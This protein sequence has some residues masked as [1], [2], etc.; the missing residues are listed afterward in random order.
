MITADKS[1]LA[2]AV[3]YRFFRNRARTTF[4]ALRV[5]GLDNVPH[6]GANDLPAEPD[7]PIVF[8]GN[9]PSW[10]DAIV[11]LLLSY[12]RFHHDAYAM[13]EEK[14]L[15]RYRFFRKIGCFSVVREDPRSAVRSLAYA[16]DLLRGTPRALWMYPQGVLTSV[17]QRPLRFF[18]GAAR[19]LRDLGDVFAV[20]TAFRYEFVGD[21]RPEIFVSFGKAWR[22]RND[23]HVHVHMT[24]SILSQLVEHEMDLQRE[25]IICRDFSSYETILEGKKSIN[26]RW[27]AMRG[28]K[29][30]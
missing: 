6:P 7:C 20:P 18:G 25:D 9:H 27:D 1:P 19:L 2:E 11:P 23:E 8:I 14:Q 12:G 3:L 5:K 26:E 10:W 22:I 24:T 30:G 4:A 13:M 15:A 29:P 28:K 17:E 21:E 16:A